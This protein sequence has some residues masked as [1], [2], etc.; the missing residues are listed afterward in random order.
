MVLTWRAVSSLF[1]ALPNTIVIAATKPMIIVCTSYSPPVCPPSKPESCTCRR[2]AS[3]G[4]LLAPFPRPL[5]AT[6]RHHRCLLWRAE[7]DRRSNLSPWGHIRSHGVP[8]ETQ[9]IPLERP[10]DLHEARPN[11]RRRSAGLVTAHEP[12]AWAARTDEGVKF[13]M[14]TGLAGRIHAL[15]TPTFG[16]TQPRQSTAIQPKAQFGIGIA[17]GNMEIMVIELP[18]GLVGWLLGKSESPR[19][20]V[21]PQLKITWG[22]LSTRPLISRDQRR[23]PAELIVHADAPEIVLHFHF[24]G[25]EGSER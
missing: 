10:H 21:Q 2:M 11:R 17:P 25:R 12:A 6:R 18:S 22:V 24:A 8:D 15:E 20:G 4:P 13:L 1:A 16:T 7:P 5:R 23:R 14:C 19:W 3:S 9:L